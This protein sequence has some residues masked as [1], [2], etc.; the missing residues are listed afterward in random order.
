MSVCNINNNYIIVDNFIKSSFYS[1]TKE[2]V[3]TLNDEKTHTIAKR[4]K[5]FQHSELSRFDNIHIFQGSEN[6]FQ[7]SRVY[8]VEWNCDYDMRW[9]PFD[10]Q[11]CRMTFTTDRSSA[12]FIDLGIQDMKYLGPKDL[13]QY[14]IR[15]TYSQKTKSG[16]IDIFVVLG[17]RLLG[18]LYFTYN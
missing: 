14:F 4:E 15:S 6:H 18:I 13:T 1:N 5:F 17:R 11:T 12:E 9:Y 16:A 10:T 3:P 8:N 2:K 7:T